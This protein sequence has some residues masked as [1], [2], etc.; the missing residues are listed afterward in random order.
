MLTRS[1]GKIVPKRTQSVDS[2]WSLRAFPLE[3]FTNIPGCVSYLESEKKI[4][5]N[6]LASH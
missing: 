2:R 5:Q 4:K 6:F 1:L 3:V